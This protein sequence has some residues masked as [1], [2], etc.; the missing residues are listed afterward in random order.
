MVTDIYKYIGVHTHTH[1][2]NVRNE[3]LSSSL[4]IYTIGLRK[5]SKVK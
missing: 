2:E 5:K 1:T 3:G 4:Y